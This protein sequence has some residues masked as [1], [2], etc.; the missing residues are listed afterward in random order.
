MSVGGRQAERLLLKRNSLIA[1]Q[2]ITFS[3]PE[4]W[5]QSISRYLQHPTPRHSMPNPFDR[6]RPYNGQYSI[7]RRQCDNYI[8]SFLD[9]CS[10]HTGRRSHESTYLNLPNTEGLIY[11]HADKTINIELYLVP[12]RLYIIWCPI[13]SPSPALQ[14]TYSHTISAHHGLR[15]NLNCVHVFPYN[16]IVCSSAVIYTSFITESQ[17]VI[18]I[19]Q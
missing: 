1:I 4:L 9:F 19:P 16:K 15:S 10:R 6:L 11:T 17:L 18:L 12:G 7:R 3:V 2:I 13:S 8:V 5:R 14:S